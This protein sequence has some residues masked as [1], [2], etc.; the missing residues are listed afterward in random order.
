M[1]WSVGYAQSDEE[2]ANVFIEGKIYGDVGIKSVSCWIENGLIYISYEKT[3]FP[4]A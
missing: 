2:C 1:G 4:A 3:H